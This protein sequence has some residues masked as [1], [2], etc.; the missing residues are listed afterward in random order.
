[1]FLYRPPTSICQFYVK[2]LYIF[3][4]AL[5]NHLQIVLKGLQMISLWNVSI[6]SNIQSNKRINLLPVNSQ[7]QNYNGSFSYYWVT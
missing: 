4:L 6:S 1:M 2:I 3:I 7:Y 5:T